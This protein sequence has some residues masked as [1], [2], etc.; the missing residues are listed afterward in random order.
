MHCRLCDRDGGDAACAASIG[1]LAGGRR[2][3]VGRHTMQMV[4]GCLRRLRASRPSRQS[5]VATPAQKSG[6]RAVPPT[7]RRC[8]WQDRPRI[9]VVRTRL[10]CWLLRDLRDLLVACAVCRGSSGRVICA[11]VQPQQSAGAAFDGAVHASRTRARGFDGTTASS[12]AQ[13]QQHAGA[14]AL[15]P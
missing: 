5:T 15:L 9:V 8:L 3:T 10:S 4:D 11:W 2:R 6:G 14:V 12:P 7:F 1:V 13:Q